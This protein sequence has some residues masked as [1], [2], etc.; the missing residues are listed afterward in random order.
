[1]Y[2]P[3]REYLTRLNRK[4]DVMRRSRAELDLIRQEH[5]YDIKILDV[6]IPA[7]QKE[8]DYLYGLKNQADESEIG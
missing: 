3:D 1:M 7:L 8:L 5:V 6:M 4:L 2:F